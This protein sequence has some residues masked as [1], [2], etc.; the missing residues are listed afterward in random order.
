M[1][2]Q[3]INEQ[4]ETLEKEIAAAEAATEAPNNETPS[5]ESSNPAVSTLENDADLK[6]IIESR[7]QEQV[8]KEK[9][10]F[11][12]KLD[13]LYKARDEAIKEKVALQEEKRQEEIRRM[14]SEGRHKEIAELKLAELQAKLETVQKENTR[15]ARDHQVTDAMKSIEFRSD[16]A[17]EMCR[18]RIM[19][20]LAQT[21]DGQWVH[22]S[23]ISIK[24]YVE[25]FVKD[26]DNSFLFKTKPNQG[27][28]LAGHGLNPTTPYSS[29]K[30][31]SALD[32]TTD[33]M[34]ESIRRDMAEGK[35]KPTI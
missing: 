16:I 11:K 8:N 35:I 14:E 15:L 6:Q 10:A 28:N 24:E 1:S 17:G 5:E 19:G 7:V 29:D 34:L 18:E 13:E 32:M 4:I 21:E 12:A 33:E 23:G 2:E 3:Q 31:K 30:P 9:A 22:R 27:N 25:Q 26:D 20:Q